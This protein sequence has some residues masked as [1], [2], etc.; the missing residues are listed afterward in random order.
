MIQSKVSGMFFETRET[1]CTRWANKKRSTLILFILSSIIDRFSKSFHWHTLQTIC[2]NVIIIYPTTL[3][4][5]F[6]TTL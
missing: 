5:R 2:N 1:Q 3:R 4:M 6:Y